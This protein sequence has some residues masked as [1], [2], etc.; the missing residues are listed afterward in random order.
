MERRTNQIGCCGIALL[1]MLWPMI[2]VTI[3]KIIASVF[4]CGVDESGVHPC[5]VLGLDLGG[6]LHSMWGMGWFFL[7]TIPSGFIALA[8]SLFSLLK[9]IREERMQDE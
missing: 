9:D 3:A 5:V 8:I 7:L 2:S 6:L 1:W 4:N